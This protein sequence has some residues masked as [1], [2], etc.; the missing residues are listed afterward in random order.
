MSLRL[1][2]CW[3]RGKTFNKYCIFTNFF[4]GAHGDGYGS[5]NGEGWCDS[6]ADGEGDGVVMLIIGVVL[7]VQVEMEVIG[8]VW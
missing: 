2:I 5:D 7:E 8:M 1:C 4:R 3:F 6:G